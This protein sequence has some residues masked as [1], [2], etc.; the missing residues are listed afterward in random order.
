M[1]NK[2][3][4]KENSLSIGKKELGDFDEVIDTLSDASNK[5]W[6]VENTPLNIGSSNTSSDQHNNPSVSSGLPKKNE[7]L[8]EKTTRQNLFSNFE[9]FINKF[10]S[11]R[12]KNLFSQSSISLTRNRK[13]NKNKK[14]KTESN[15]DELKN[16]DKKKKNF[17]DN[18]KTPFTFSNLTNPFNNS[19]KVQ[20]VVEH[21]LSIQYHSTGKK[22]GMFPVANS[23]KTNLK[24]TNKQLEA[25]NANS[26]KREIRNSLQMYFQAYILFYENGKGFDNFEQ[27]LTD[28]KTGLT[29]VQPQYPKIVKSAFNKFMQNLSRIRNGS[30]NSLIDSISNEDN[31][32]TR[33]SNIKTI[34]DGTN[35]LI[36]KLTGKKK[37]PSPESLEGYSMPFKT[38][39]QKKKDAKQIPHFSAKDVLNLAKEKNKYKNTNRLYSK[40]NTMFSNTTRTTTTTEIPENLK[41]KQQNRR[42]S[43][44]SNSNSGKNPLN[45][46]RK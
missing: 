32:S 43:G 27:I 46:Q 33:L 19:N 40:S 3:K 11:Y 31:K 18:I 42:P 6:K 10:L 38:H 28:N 41:H 34:Y 13:L 44:P 5:T 21:D 15:L 39:K 25:L 12:P 37:K 26:S 20:P 7:L 30:I 1:K 22:K 45:F 29:K 17:F 36:L 16:K 14:L 4:E 24:N 23:L 35:N 9:G 2:G 8:T